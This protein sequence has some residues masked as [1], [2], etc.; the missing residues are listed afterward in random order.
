MNNSVSVVDYVLFG[1]VIVISLLIGSIFA[2]FKESTEVDFV[3]AGRKLGAI[4]AAISTFVS[5]WSAVTILGIPGEVYIYGTQIFMLS[6]I[7]WEYSQ[8]NCLSSVLCTIIFV[9]TFARKFRELNVV[10]IFQY[11][12]MRFNKYVKLVAS[13]FFIVQNIIYL[14]AVIYAPAIAIESILNVDLTATLVI[15]TI[16]CIIY[17]AVGGFRGV[18]WTDMFQFAVL[19]CGLFTLV[20]YGIQKSHGLHNIFKANYM[21]GR[22]EFFV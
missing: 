12:E 7:H 9:P 14:S 21:T 16:I 18:V 4:P 1:A 15:A 3:L 17:S 8:C 10:S 6:K 19:L 2:F 5:F 22:I 20:G 11:L 13:I